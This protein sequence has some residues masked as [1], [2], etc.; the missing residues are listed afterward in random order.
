MQVSFGVALN[1][2]M[3]RH[4][5]ASWAAAIEL[6]HLTARD[7]LTMQA[8]TLMPPITPFGYN[9]AYPS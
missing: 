9:V 5:R 4:G 2:M 7:P 8:L 3:R 6:W 1:A